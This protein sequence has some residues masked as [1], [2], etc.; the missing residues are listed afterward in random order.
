MEKKRARKSACVCLCVSW[1]EK[2]ARVR[3][4]KRERTVDAS[5]NVKLYDQSPNLFKAMKSW[6]EWG[7]K[8]EGGLGANIF[9]PTSK[10]PYAI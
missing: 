4:R 9:W 5:V 2:C 1:R 3:E 10:S 6:I 7:V 8:G